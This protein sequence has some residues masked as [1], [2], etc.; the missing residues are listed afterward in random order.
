MNCYTSN[1]NWSD[2]FLPEIKQ[3]IGGY[4]LE[5]APDAFDHMQATDLMMLE[6]R[7][8]RVA[9]RVRRPGFAQRY[10][11]QFTIRSAV[12]SGR[13][14]EL[15]KIVNG[16]GDWMFYGHSDAAQT[17]LDAWWLI[18]LR[19]FRAGLIRHMANAPQ[20]VMGDQANADGTRFKWFDVRSFPAEPPLV[21]ACSQR[22]GPT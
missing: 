21:V 2:R 12:A 4:L 19:A 7:D 17:G 5:T 8:M 15:S 1:R 14:T 20:I 16:N 11:H 3:L 13:Q 6:A 9:A 18:D 22:G 10:P